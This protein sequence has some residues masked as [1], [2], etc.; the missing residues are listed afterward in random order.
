MYSHFGD[1]IR[2]I[3][4]LVHRQDDAVFILHTPIGAIAV[5]R[6]V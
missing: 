2:E 3:R 6:F 4:G 5:E 1:I